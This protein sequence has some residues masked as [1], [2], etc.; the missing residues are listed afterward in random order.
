VPLLFG[1][2]TKDTHI[3]CV[4]KVAHYWTLHSWRNALF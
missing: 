4:G 3:Q 2:Y 1:N